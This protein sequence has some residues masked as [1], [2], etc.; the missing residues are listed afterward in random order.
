M[1]L[2]MNLLSITN[3]LMALL[4]IHFKGDCYG[5]NTSY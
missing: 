1:I 3:E 2:H 4:R 5:E